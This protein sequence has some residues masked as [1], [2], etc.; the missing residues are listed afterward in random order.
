MIF[1][2][3]GEYSIIYVNVCD[4]LDIVFDEWCYDF[5]IY[6]FWRFWFFN[7]LCMKSLYSKVL[8]VNV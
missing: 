1:C 6:I 7:L 2:G 4:E 5:I 8:V 3:Y